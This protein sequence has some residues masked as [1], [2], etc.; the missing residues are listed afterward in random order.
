LTVTEATQRVG[1]NA[2]DLQ[3]ERAILLVRDR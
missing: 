2:C 1:G 3:A